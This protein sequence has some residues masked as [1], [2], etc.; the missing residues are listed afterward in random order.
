MVSPR[1]SRVAGLS[2]SCTTARVRVSS[3]LNHEVAAPARLPDQDLVKC[4]LLASESVPRT[5][6]PALRPRSPA[7]GGD[8]SGD[9]RA[10]GGQES[11]SGGPRRA[12]PARR[13][14]HAAASASRWNRRAASPGGRV[15]RRTSPV[16]RSPACRDAVGTSHILGHCLDEWNNPLSAANRSF[17]QPSGR[18]TCEAGATVGFGMEAGG[19]VGA[20]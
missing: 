13:A 11:S 17:V 14:A 12:R 7:S 18:Q 5:G 15:A 2:N 20:T 10:L 4:V 1:F 6:A 19:G 3:G 9:R 8:M 16:R